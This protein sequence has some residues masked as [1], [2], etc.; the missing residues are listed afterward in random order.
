MFNNNV[1]DQYKTDYSIKHVICFEQ[2]MT[3]NYQ[4]VVIKI[5]FSVK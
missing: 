1:F 3:N 2:Q 5:S 4:A